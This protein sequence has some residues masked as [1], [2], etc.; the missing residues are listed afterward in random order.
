MKVPLKWLR[1]YVGIN[2]PV[3]Q[4]IE[5]LTLAGLEVANT[6]VLGLPIPEGLRVKPDEVA[7]VWDKD[8]I[9]IGKVLSVEKHPNADRLSLPTIEYGAR[10]PN[11]IVTGALNL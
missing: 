8:K 2:L 5:R 11:R 10:Q 7:P 1:D 4:L 9:V 3:P 6:R